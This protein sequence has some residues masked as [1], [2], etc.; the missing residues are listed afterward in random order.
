M[1]EEVQIEAFMRRFYPIQGKLRGYVFSA[2]RAYHAPED[3]LQ[4]GAI[5]VVKKA[6]VYDA[7]RPVLPGFMG[8]ARN[9]TQRL[10]RARGREAGN[11]RLTCCKNLCRSMRN[12]ATRR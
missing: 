8:I 1:T 7:S 10:Y 5:V 6:A 2:T 12:T 11:V 4:E 9:Q 3:I